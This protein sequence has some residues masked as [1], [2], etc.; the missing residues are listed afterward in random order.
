MSTTE[1][2]KYD[3]IGSIEATFKTAASSNYSAID[4]DDIGKLC[5][6]SAAETAAIRSDTTE[7]PILGRI[8]A[9]ESDDSVTVQTDGFMEVTA[10]ETVAVTTVSNLL[11]TYNG[12]LYVKSTALTTP[13][14]NVRMI[15][16]GSTTVKAVIKLS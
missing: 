10:G 15:K 8:T 9:Y 1:L 13:I 3:N 5:S 14:P 4:E 7:T 11:G 2:Y 12:L 6:L 16:A